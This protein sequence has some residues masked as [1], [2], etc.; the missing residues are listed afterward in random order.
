MG[1][2]FGRSIFVRVFLFPALGVSFHHF[3]IDPYVEEAFDPGKKREYNRFDK[4]KTTIDMI[5]HGI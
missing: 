3:F 5:A 4:F 2:T 1:S